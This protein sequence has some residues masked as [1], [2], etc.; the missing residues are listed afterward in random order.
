MTI[1]EMYKLIEELSKKE[2]DAYGIYKQVGGMN[3]TVEYTVTN[4]DS[5]LLEDSLRYATTTNLNEIKASMASR[6]NSEKGIFEVTAEDCIRYQEYYE[7]A[8][9]FNRMTNA[10]YASKVGRCS[11]MIKDMISNVK[12]DYLTEINNSIARHAYEQP[13]ITIENH[14]RL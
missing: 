6:F 7:F 10:I 9:M 13:E 2:V 14:V 3:G 5:F 11:K 12:R 8:T 1:D 4:F